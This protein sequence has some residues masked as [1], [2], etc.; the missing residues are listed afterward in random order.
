MVRILVF[1]FIAV[2]VGSSNTCTQ[3]DTCEACYSSSFLCHWCKDIPPES[4]GGGSKGSCHY[5]LSPHGCQVGDACSLDDCSERQTCSSCSMG[6]CKWCASA[7]KCVS[8]YSWTCALPSN[9]LPNSECQRTEPEFV[10]YLRAIPDWAIYV[11]T[12][13]YGCIVTASIFGL[14]H[15]RRTLVSVAGQYQP[16]QEEP[17]VSNIRSRIW[18]FRGIATVWILVAALVGVAFVLAALFWPSAPQLSM[19]NAQLMW[20]DTLNM[21]VNSVTTGKATVESELLITIYNPNRLGLKINS[22]NGNIYYKGTTVGSLDLA[23]I[24]AQGGSASDGIGVMS[25]DGFDHITEMFYDFNVAHKLLLEFE[26]FVNFD[27]GSMNGFSLAAPRFQMNVNNPPPQQHC[28][29]KE[30]TAPGLSQIDYEYI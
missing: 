22:V 8:P 5:K 27:V 23:S 2:R 28:K 6:G 20:S 11:F 29:C 26:L 12:V 24:D 4:T 17:D 1:Y 16:L 9:C 30:F 14:Y 13:V 25:F 10:G 7:Q 21:I 18:L 3:A 15:L 19:C